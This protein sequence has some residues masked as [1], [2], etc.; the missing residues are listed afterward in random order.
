M[1]YT[2]SKVKDRWNKK[3][4][5]SFLVR[6]KAGRKEQIQARASSLGVSLNEY[7]NNLINQDMGEDAKK[8]DE[9]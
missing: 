8:A 6:V 2:S 5:D 9:D 1:S 7:I 4:Y 3:A